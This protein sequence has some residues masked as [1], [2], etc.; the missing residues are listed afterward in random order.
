M[1]L[2]AA[3]AHGSLFWAAGSV[4]ACA[5]GFGAYLAIPQEKKDLILILGRQAL[6]PLQFASTLVGVTGTRRAPGR[7]QQR[8]AQRPEGGR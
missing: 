5:T 1:S 2:S 3:M 7:A 8:G 4:A 6:M